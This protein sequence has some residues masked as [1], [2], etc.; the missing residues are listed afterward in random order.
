MK[1]IQACLEVTF[2]DFLVEFCILCIPLFLREKVGMVV[3][4]IAIS[5]GGLELDSRASQSRH[6]VATAATF[7]LELC[8]PSSKLRKWSP[9]LVMLRRNTASMIKICF[10][11]CLIQNHH[12]D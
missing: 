10:L 1:R 3:S 11:I 8:C 12:K 4:D 6:S 5:V 7:V 9:A 2:P